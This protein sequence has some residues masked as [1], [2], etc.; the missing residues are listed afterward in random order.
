MK[1]IEVW[2][3]VSFDLLKYGL[4]NAFLG[5]FFLSFFL[6]SLNLVFHKCA[7]ILYRSVA[8][9]TKPTMIVIA[10]LN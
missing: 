9:I 1:C 7:S 6:F 2:S 4:N 3:L 5:S 8:T 10:F